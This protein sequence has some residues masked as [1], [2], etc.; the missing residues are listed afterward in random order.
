MQNFPYSSKLEAA[1]CST[2]PFVK[3]RK[4]FR[5]ECLI[6]PDPNLA[7]CMYEHAPSQR[8]VRS[9]NMSQKAKKKQT[10]GAHT[11]QRPRAKNTDRELK[12]SGGRDENRKQKKNLQSSDKQSKQKRFFPSASMKSCIVVT[13]MGLGGSNFPMPERRAWI[14]ATNAHRRLNFAFPFSAEHRLC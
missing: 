4:V 1:R 10:N 13:C 7:A 6:P 3:A 11:E 8:L 9:L 5:T 14:S 2:H 12:P